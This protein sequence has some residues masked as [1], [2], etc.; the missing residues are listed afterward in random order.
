MSRYIIADIKRILKRI[1]YWVI[2]LLMIWLSS[3]F[4]T[5]GGVS[6]MDIVDSTKMLFVYAC[7]PCGFLEIIYVLGEDLRARTA[8]IAIGIGI[9]REK[10]VIAKWLECFIIT[11]IHQG[12]LL[13]AVFLY[14]VNQKAPFTASD[15]KE[16]ALVL[17]MSV[18]GTG[19]YLALVFPIIVAANGT[20]LAIVVYIFLS[21][22]LINKGLGYLELLRPVQKLHI[23]GKTP[24]NL[25]NV[26][27]SR[28]ILGTFATGQWIGVILFIAVFL[29][30]S[31]FIYKKQE[32]EF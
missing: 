13:L 16:V 22:G 28:M 6:S 17:L 31:I 10:V 12:L 9:S 2:V 32:L 5:A 29:G 7:V 3:S 25:I 23:I 8:Q 4:T 20:S 15:W 19:V 1:S 11:A 27:R 18:I 24:T 14:A 21:T 26:C 30:L